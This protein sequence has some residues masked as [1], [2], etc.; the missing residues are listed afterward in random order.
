MISTA[1]FPARPPMTAPFLSQEHVTRCWDTLADWWIRR[2]RQHSLGD[3]FRRT[4]LTPTVLQILGEVQ[5]RR[6]LDMGC[7]EGYLARLLAR[8]GAVVTGVDVS[9][10]LLSAAVQA[11]ASEHL[12]LDYRLGSADNLSFLG[13]AKFDLAVANML[14]MDIP[15]YRAAISEVV[16]HLVR[17][18][19]VVWTILHPATFRET[20]EWLLEGTT[21]AHI[22]TIPQHFGRWARMTDLAPDAPVGIPYFHR[23][24]DDYVTAF[25]LLGFKIV[26]LVEPPPPNDIIE[27]WSCTIAEIGTR[28]PVVAFD[29]EL[30]HLS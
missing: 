10:P 13:S 25:E 15:R 19:R 9:K 12:G 23:T 4:M 1:A 21:Q 17:G 3:P 18:G 28:S 6:I 27:E 5:G 14:L 29:T 26:N 20:G 30:A 16:S 24:M 2:I 8:S 11:E 22:H 7:G